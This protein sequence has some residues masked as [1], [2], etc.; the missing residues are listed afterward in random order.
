MRARIAVCLLVPACWALCFAAAAAVGVDALGFKGSRSG[1][2]DALIEPLV[3]IML[4]FVTLALP[5]S[6]ARVAMLGGGALG[7]GTVSRAVSYAAGRTLY[8]AGAHHLPHWAGGRSDGAE[9]RS[10]SSS[11]AATAAVAASAVTAATGGAA[12]PA[13]AAAGAAG[14]G[15]TSAAAGGADGDR[16]RRGRRHAAAREPRAAPRPRPAARRATRAG[17][18][19]YAPAR[20]PSHADGSG[21]QSPS[22]HGREHH[23][24]LELLAA[25]SR[26]ANRPVS[27]A[28]AAKALRA[29]PAD[30]RRGIDGLVREHGAGAR[31]HLAYQALGDWTDDQREALRTLAAATPDVR[32]HALTDVLG[33]PAPDMSDALA[34]A[35]DE[36]PARPGP[37]DDSRSEVSGPS[38]RHAYTPPNPVHEPAAPRAVADGPDDDGAE[39]LR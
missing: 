7:S 18:G 12:A 39:G 24:A 4:L 6:L 15:A 16:R 17:S 5:R 21:L 25:E 31:E 37:A 32:A 10:E 36:P 30:T 35:I 38:T 27:P 2:L 14:P 34:P 33:A 3:A 11:G 29:L 19:A 23:H 26:E 28:E 8:G 13:A 9:P 22:F 1:A 20:P